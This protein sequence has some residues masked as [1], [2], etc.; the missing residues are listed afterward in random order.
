MNRHPGRRR[1]RVCARLLGI[2]DYPQAQGIGSGPE[3]V[4][5]NDEFGHAQAIP[6]R[7]CLNDALQ[8]RPIFQLGWPPDRQDDIRGCRAEILDRLCNDASAAD[9]EGLPQSPLD[10]LTAAARHV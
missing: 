7:L 4:L 8:M 9:L 10:Y 3:L 2:G 6:I 5:E 1:S